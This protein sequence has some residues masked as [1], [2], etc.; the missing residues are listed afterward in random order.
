MASEFKC[1]TRATN[2]RAESVLKGS[3]IYVAVIL[4]AEHKEDV[5][6]QELRMYVAKNWDE[7]SI[8]EHL[9]ELE[10]LIAKANVAEQESEANGVEC[11]ENSGP[12]SSRR[13]A[14]GRS[15][16]FFEAFLL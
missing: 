2:P 12:A 10:Q 11:V 3:Q 8:D 13:K 7:S 16:A 4:V 9:D 6:I 15:E 14:R 5:H 1:N